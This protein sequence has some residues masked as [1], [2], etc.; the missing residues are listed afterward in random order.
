MY[1][2]I[3]FWCCLG[4]VRW[5]IL[6]GQLSVLRIGVC[7]RNGCDDVGD[8]SNVYWI[9]SGIKLSPVE[10]CDEAFSSR[11]VFGASFQHWCGLRGT[12][13]TAWPLYNLV[14]QSWCSRRPVRERLHLDLVRN[15]YSSTPRRESVAGVVS[16]WI[17]TRGVSIRA[18]SRPIRTVEWVVD[19]VGPICSQPWDITS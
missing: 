5:R 13:R 15:Q 12:M 16:S 6:G 19:V 17:W 18:V 3:V 2:F 4:K 14:R 11:T 1:P 7:S 8:R 9:A 10:Y